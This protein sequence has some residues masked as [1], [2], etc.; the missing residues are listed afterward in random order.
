M[1]PSGDPADETTST[2]SDLLAACAAAKAEGNAAFGGG[3]LRLAADRYDAALRLW[4]ELVE[5]SVSP[6][7]L[8][9][10]Q[11]VR[12]DARNFF[13]VVMSSFPLF[14]EYFLKDLGSDKA[15]WVGDAGGDL[16][17]FAKRELRAVT[18]EAL[19]LRLA[20]VQNLAA[21]HLKQQ[22]WEQAVRWADAA[23]VIEGKAAK[24]LL[25]KGAA[26][27]RLD[28][29]GPASDVLA[30]AAGVVPNDLEVRRL[31][32]EAEA[33]RS[34]TWVCVTG[35]CG[36]WGIVCGG[37][38]VSGANPMAVAPAER[39]ALEEQD[40]APPACDSA[41]ERP[42]AEAQSS[43]PPAGEDTRVDIKGGVAAT[44]TSES[45]TTASP[46]SSTHQDAP[47][48]GATDESTA[49]RQARSKE[50]AQPTDRGERA[51]AS[52][53]S[54]A[55]QRGYPPGDLGAAGDEA[56]HEAKD[57]S[58]A[59]ATF[60]FMTAFVCAAAVATA[61]LLGRESLEASSSA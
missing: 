47:E 4:Q 59:M 40:G 2:P 51:E 38:V 18:R 3:D 31:L 57:G 14:D 46:R 48:S 32:R 13:G 15:I 21:V 10:G 44:G 49:P 33:K 53:D 26:L 27:L 52:L 5:S 42:A 12:Y 56:L 28:K 61:L 7:T 54:A 34:P 30:T 6:Q 9:V 60:I 39:P 35:C 1:A 29:P 43:V 50:G 25:R 16:R 45:S 19:D 24:A 58:G 36:P 11:L 22:E 20:V 37:P 17:R 8:E 41:T 23:L 55:P